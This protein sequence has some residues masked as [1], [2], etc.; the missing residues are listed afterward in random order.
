MS[1]KKIVSSAVKE[2]SKWVQN[3]YLLQ[4]E[5]TKQPMHVLESPYQLVKL[6]RKSMHHSPHPSTD[7]LKQ[8]ILENW[9]SLDDFFQHG[10]GNTILCGQEIV[11]WC[12]SGFAAG[13]LHGIS[14]ATT[15][16]HRGKKLAQL[17][18]HAFINDCL[19][20]GQAPY[21][22]CTATNTASNRIAKNIGLTLH[23]DYHVYEFRF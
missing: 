3:V 11:T 8:T 21:W 20:H 19:D 12:F 17:A 13:N 18:A 9:H 22:D 2:L 16:A 6:T 14:I 4:K 5:L 23:F 10:I 1:S 7:A 15:K